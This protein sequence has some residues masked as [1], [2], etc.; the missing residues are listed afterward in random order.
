[1]PV[2]L[3][4]RSTRQKLS[5]EKMKP[6]V[7]INVRKLQKEEIRQKVQRNIENKLQTVRTDGMNIE[8]I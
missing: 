3:T 2:I 8:E 6:V 4:L 1:M 5:S 7:Q